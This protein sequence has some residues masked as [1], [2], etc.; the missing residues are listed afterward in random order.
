MTAAQTTGL[1]KKLGF[2]DVQLGVTDVEEP[3]ISLCFSLKLMYHILLLWCS[4]VFYPNPAPKFPVELMK[5]DVLLSQSC[6]KTQRNIFLVPRK[7][8]SLRNQMEEGEG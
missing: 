5:S 8:R 1:S 4:R 7:D 6:H 2:A 3:R